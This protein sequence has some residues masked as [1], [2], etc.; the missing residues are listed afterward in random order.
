M[1]DRVTLEQLD[2]G[3]LFSQ[4]RR[5]R[6]TTLARVAARRFAHRRRRQ[7]DR[8][9][10]S[11]EYLRDLARDDPERARRKAIQAIRRK[12]SDDRPE[13]IGEAERRALAEIRPHLVEMAWTHHRPADLAALIA[14]RARADQGRLDRWYFIRHMARRL[15]ARLASSADIPGRPDSRPPDNRPDIGPDLRARVR[16]CTEIVTRYHR[17]PEIPWD[18]RSIQA[19]LASTCCAGQNS[20]PVITLVQFACVR[21]HAAALDSPDPAA[22]IRPGSIFPIP[23]RDRR[24]AR[25]LVADLRAAGADVRVRVI[26]SDVDPELYIVPILHPG[27]TAHGELSRRLRD[28]LA[29]YREAHRAWLETLGA[30]LVSWSSLGREFAHWRQLHDRARDAVMSPS[31]RH[32]LRRQTALVSQY[33]GPGGYLAA[34]ARPDDARLADMAAGKCAL[35]AAQGCALPRLF[36]GSTVIV[37]QNEAPLDLRTRMLTAM[38]ATGARLHVIA[39][40][41]DR[42]PWHHATK[43]ATRSADAAG[44][45]RSP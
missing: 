42:R 29:G 44:P 2:C 20:G 14:E 11:S 17:V 30:R 38:P 39:P 16:A 35:Y 8:A 6:A 12:P 7:I 40:Y 5:H 3:G 4:A 26:L 27:F 24:T 33:F 41:P 9:I 32:D 19:S 23:R 22:V 45:R 15:R 36:A 25:R 28:H 1:D 34:I 21:L 10:A 18:A 37:L 31:G 43:P 13:I